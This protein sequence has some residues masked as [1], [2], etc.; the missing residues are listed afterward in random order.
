MG[1]LV[2]PQLTSA[3]FVADDLHT[4]DT[5]TLITFGANTT[6][7]GALAATGTITVTAGS[8]VFTVQN[9]PF[10]VTIITSSTDCTATATTSA[11]VLTVTL[12]NDGGNTCGLPASTAFS[13]SIAANI[14]A[15]ASTAGAV[16][17]TMAT[18][19]DDTATASA[20]GYTLVEPQLTSATF[21]AN[22]LHTGDTPTLITFGATT[23][24]SGALAATGTITVTAGSNVFT[25]QNT[26]FTV[27]IIT[28]S[29][30]CTA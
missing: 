14:A 17:F 21:V 16:T 1:T 24:A 29:T 20:T 25:V 19:A 2:A 9:T 4:G 30:D 5:P 10:T 12:A 15:S 6:A 11:T 7:S 8:N 26:P 3:T 28:S 27:T 22:N 18:S 13:M 23:T